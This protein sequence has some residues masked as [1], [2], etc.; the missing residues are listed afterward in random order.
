M[1]RVKSKINF[2]DQRMMLIC[3]IAVISI[4]VGIINPN[5]FAV[6]TLSSIL[7]QIS[8]TG[9]LTMGMAFLMI[10]GGVDLSMGT[11]MALCGV[12]MSKTI[13]DTDNVLLA[14]L[15]GMITGV[16]GGL[17][18]G[19]IV[20]KSKCVPL[21]ITLGTSNIFLGIS[22]I[23]SLGQFMKFNNKFDFLAK[24][25]F[26]LFPISLIVLFLVVLIIYI[27]LNYTVLGR[28][29]VAIGGNEENAYLSGL[30]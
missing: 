11:L 30:V 29:M 26:N 4:I 3:I 20:S 27:L 24:K 13:V 15:L 17:L 28:R 1:N 14:L 5:F 2:S 7:Q 9:I 19:I 21:V 12:V 25:I 6:K 23:I 8:V 10:S 22:L 18:N 16:L